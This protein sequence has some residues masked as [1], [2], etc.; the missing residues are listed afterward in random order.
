MTLFKKNL[1]VGITVLVALLLL[2]VMILR[3]GDLPAKWF[4]RA[5]FPVTF[6]S[7]R[8]DGLSEG[9]P[10]SYRGVSVGKVQHVRLGE[11][12]ASVVINV[13][14]NQDAK[15]PENVQGSITTTLLGGASSLSLV[16]VNKTP[17]VRTPLLGPP[18]LPQGQLKPGARL[19][20]QFRGVDLLPRE[21][22]DLASSVRNLSEQF[23]QSHLI[24]HFDQVVVSA[25]TQLSKVGKLLDDV[26]GVVEDKDIRQNLREAIT[27]FHSVSANLEQ[28][29]KN[30]NTQLTE[31]SS[32]ANK[33]MTTT[34]VRVDQLGGQVGDRLVQLS[35]VLDNLN[36][37]MT[38]LNSGN[39]TA[40][41]LIND[42]KLYES[43]LDTSR[44]LNLTIKDLKRVVEQWEQEGV[45]V[46]F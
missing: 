12:Q 16:L 46:K 27:N 43:L 21:L 45:H 3:F 19:K 25:N 37:V 29:S 31:V 22:T 2:G 15:V 26:T 17:E 35:K 5:Q 18:I 20:A 40:A 38:K 8:A 41:M 7:E 11:D 6:D 14:I 23:Q 34:Q 10:V 28:L 4:A 44:T 33:L 32:N 36:G 9:S 42:P 39:G 1:L 13:L 24:D 30:A